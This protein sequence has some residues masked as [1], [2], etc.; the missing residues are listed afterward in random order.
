MCTDVLIKTV[1]PLKYTKLPQAK[2]VTPNQTTTT[3][4]KTTQLT[5]P[6]RMGNAHITGAG[7]S[8][9]VIQHADP[10]KPDR[11]RLEKR[12]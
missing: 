1:Y 6:N 12:N 3:N 10:T 8:W 9:P 5:G 2:R 4:Y 7:T 11:V